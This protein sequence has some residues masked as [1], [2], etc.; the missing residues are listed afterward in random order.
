MYMCVLVCI[1]TYPCT[2]IPMNTHEED[3]AGVGEDLGCLPPRLPF[4]S[5]ARSLT[6]SEVLVSEL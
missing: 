2:S 5:L 1:H 6:E 3:G 4:F